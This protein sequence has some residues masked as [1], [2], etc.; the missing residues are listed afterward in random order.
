[1]PTLTRPLRRSLPSLPWRSS[2]ATLA[3]GLAAGAVLAA[4]AESVYHRP[5]SEAGGAETP[6]AA[7]P[8]TDAAIQAERIVLAS[9]ATLSDAETLSLRLRQ[10]ARIGD[11]V[12]VGTGRYLQ[13]GR[14]EELR[15][16]FESSLTCDT[17]SFE[18]T[19]VSDGL[20]CWLHR[21]TGPDPATLHR[22]DVQSV[23]SRLAELRAADPTDTAAHLGG[24]QRVLWSTREWYAFLSATAGEFEGKGVWVVE[25]RWLPERLANLVPDLAAAARRPGGVEP[26]ELPEG[27]PWAVRLT[28]GRDDLVPRRLEMLGVPGPRPAVADAPVEP[29]AVIEILDV[30]FDAPVDTAAFFYQPAEEGL[31][32]LTAQQCRMMTLF[33]R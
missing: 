26:T 20:F 28:V 4:G 12:L 30:V 15:F 17:E 1:M 7:Q 13:V 2:V 23:R 25:G 29:I 22:I 9:L 24:L 19:E 21:R 31:I 32:D 18:L 6:A 27:M 10:R 8:V 11:R 3:C 16:R 5:G 33:R 14:G